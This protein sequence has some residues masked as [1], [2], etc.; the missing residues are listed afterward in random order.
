M[1]FSKKGFKM[2]SIVSI[3]FSLMLFVS[4]AIAQDTVISGLQNVSVTVVTSAGS[5]SG[6]VVTRNVDGTNR[7]FI[8]TAGHVVRS[9]RYTNKG[10]DS[11][12]GIVVDRVEFNDAKIVKEIQEDGRR[13]GQMF[14]DAKIIKFS[15]HLTGDDIAILEVYKS[16]LIQGTVEFNL[17]DSDPVIGTDLYHV[18]SFLGL[19]GHNSLTKGIVSQNGRLIDNKPYCQVAVGAFPGSSGGGVFTTDGKYTG[20]LVRG[21][22]EMF[23]LTVPMTRIK[24]WCK[25]HDV[26]WL[27]DPSV[28][29][30]DKNKRA[31][32]V[33]DDTG[34]NY[35]PDESATK[36]FPFLFNYNKKKLA[37]ILNVRT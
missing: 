9:L 33:V 23:N 29:V 25:K 7:Q 12:T 17:S 26:E 13:V 14:F 27:I 32:M 3:M 19:D 11:T 30:P 10:V 35:L 5:G 31:K 2:K 24:K 20:M 36:E 22:G 6:V 34:A 1:Y 15:D 18:G 8:L 16:N 28:G 4:T 37:E 21:A